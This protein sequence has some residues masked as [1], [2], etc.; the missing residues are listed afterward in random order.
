VYAR[1]VNG[2]TLTFGVSGKLIRNS[3]VMYDRETHSLWSHL[4]GS[5]IDGPLSGAQLQVLP[6]SQTTWT[7]W[8]R[9]YPGTKVLPHD[10]PGQ[11][12]QLR[13]FTNQAAGV[14]GR[15]HDDNRLPT[16][17]KVIGVRVLDQAKAYAM[18][19][20]IRE[21]IVDDTFADE[22]LVVFKTGSE[23]ASVFRRD[24]SGQTL[25]FEASAGGTITDRET[26]SGWD[27][28][29]GKA[30]SGALMNSS[31]TPI[32]ATTSF[33]F[34]W[35]DFFPETAL[36]TGRGPATPRRALLSLI[37]LAGRD[38][39]HGVDRGLIRHRI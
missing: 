34:G 32:D 24:L 30:V 15:L 29:T 7:S 11:T 26:G 5:A 16:K 35:F 10:Y 14:R 17:A 20:I 21:K 23:S 38:W 12:D 28:L 37:F 9:A 13:Y 22:A 6:A 2:K 3:L 18:T 19:A 4:T 27:P 36:Y 1:T 8:Q 33:W 39:L 31:L 25:T